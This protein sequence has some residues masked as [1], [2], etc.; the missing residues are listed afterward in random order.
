M[1]DSNLEVIAAARAA[2]PSAKF[3]LERMRESKAER[4]HARRLFDQLRVNIRLTEAMARL[5]ECAVWRDDL[6]LI[7]ADLG[8]VREEARKFL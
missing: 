8:S 1:D 3:I 4:K 7:V 6:A 2:V 5:P